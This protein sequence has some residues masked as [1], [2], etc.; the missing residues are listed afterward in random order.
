MAGLLVSSHK[1][2]K[3]CNSSTCASTGATHD[4]KG[5]GSVSL[6]TSVIYSKGGQRKERS[7]EMS[8]LVDVTP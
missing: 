4:A 1:S 5:R 2:L 8:Q 3:N 6:P 7:E